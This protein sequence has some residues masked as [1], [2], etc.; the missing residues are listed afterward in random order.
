[1][2]N[3]K[4]GKMS[5]IVIR[6]IVIVVLIVL[7]VAGGMYMLDDSIEVRGGKA[8]PGNYKDTFTENGRVKKGQALSYIS[9]VDGNV[10]RVNAA[11]NTAVKKGDVIAVIDSADLEYE[12]Q[13]CSAEIAALEASKTE[14]SQENL[15]NRNEIQAAISEANYQLQEIEN[16][17]KLSSYTENMTVSPE[18]YI[19][20]LRVAHNQADTSLDY[21]SK[22]EDTL[23]KEIS[24]IKATVSGGDVNLLDE[25]TGAKVKELEEKLKEVQM[26]YRNARDE[27][28]NARAAYEDAVDRMNDG[29]LNKDYYATIQGDF[30]IQVQKIKANKDA[31][32]KKL[33]NNTSNAST[34]R[35]NN[36]IA[37]KLAQLAQLDKKI[38]ACT[39]VAQSDGI[40]SELPVENTNRISAGE[41]VAV[42]RTEEAFTVEANVLTSE[43]PYLAVGDKVR[44]VQKL[45]S[46]QR[47]YEGEI[48]AIYDYAE[49]TVSSLGNDEYR[50]KVIIALKD[51]T[52]LKDG[53]EINVVFDVFNQDN[54]ISVPNSAMFKKDD[55]YHV[56]VVRNDKAQMVPVEVLHR[57]GTRTAISGGISAGDVVIFDANTDDLVDGS[58]VDV[59]L[60]EK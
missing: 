33:K 48:S 41:V 26:E 38:D 37:A 49:Q 60:V 15:I 28:D 23:K 6:V 4:N 45:K 34:L 10:I 25:E 24:D 57:G 27:A 51:A 12:R 31:L 21:Y 2:K 32:E 22:L 11:K 47:E 58:S 14:I 19:N 1:M 40:V 56:F 54:V 44:L 43:V 52:D 16:Q 9:E 39:V 55:T 50:V 46:D 36:E 20:S 3:K 53:Y 29:E 18:I 7:V 8:E 13:I 17:K 59:E 5:K 35:V 30:E 42:V